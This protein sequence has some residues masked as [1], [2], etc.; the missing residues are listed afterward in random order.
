MTVDQ[1]AAEP[2]FHPDPGVHDLGADDLGAAD[3][4]VDETHRV[5]DAFL[6]RLFCAV[7][8]SATADALVTSD[9]TIAQMRTIITLAQATAAIPLGEVATAICTSLATAGRTVDRLVADG[10]VDRQED[11]GDRR[12]KRVSLTE[13]GRNLVASHT[14]HKRLFAR[15]FVATLTPESRATLHAALSPLLDDRLFRSAEKSLNQEGADA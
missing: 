6:S 3:P 12:V 9:L 14:D 11:P 8:A 15:A 10:L 2:A 7:N 4:G 1:R 13:A 5:L